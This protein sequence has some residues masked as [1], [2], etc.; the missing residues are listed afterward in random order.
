MSDKL[1]DEIASQ[2]YSMWM[3][4]PV[5]ERFLSET[6]WADC[7]NLAEKGMLSWLQLRDVFLNLALVAQYTIRDER[8]KDG[9]RRIK[10]S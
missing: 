7:M 1:T 3:N 9:T 8:E 10:G 2:M 4:S 5:A 6:T